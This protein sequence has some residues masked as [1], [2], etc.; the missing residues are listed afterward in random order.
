[1]SV[2]GHGEVPVV[3]GGQRLTSGRH[4]NPDPLR[5]LDQTRE[6]AAIHPSCDRGSNIPELLSAS[7]KHP[8]AVEA[9]PRLAAYR[10]ALAVADR[11]TCPAACSSIL[12]QDTP[13]SCSAGM[14]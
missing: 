10:P 11:S 1:M 8:A 9:S 4:R 7:D 3:V 6:A 14:G 12:H 2:P 5:D 13:T